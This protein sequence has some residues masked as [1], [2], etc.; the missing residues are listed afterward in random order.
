[1]VVSHWKDGL[2]TVEQKVTEVGF[3]YVLESADRL[4]A[5]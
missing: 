4:Q 5:K 3:G 1:M 2:Q